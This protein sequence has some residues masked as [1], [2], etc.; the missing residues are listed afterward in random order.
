M[1]SKRSTLC[2]TVLLAASACSKSENMRSTKSVALTAHDVAEPSAASAAI[3]QGPQ[4]AYSYETSYALD[5][6]G[7]AAIQA[8]HIALCAKLGA[9]RCQVASSSV[10]DGSNDE[11]NASGEA[12]LV[13]AATLADSF[14]RQLDQAV[15]A[16]GGRVTN[17]GSTADDVTKQ[18]ID[19]NARLAAKQVLTDRL[20]VLI[21][22]ADGK[23]GDLVA[24]EKA[25]AEAQGE[26]EAARGEQTA[27]AQRVAMSDISLHYASRGSGSVF[28]PVGRALFGAGAALGWSLAGLVTFIVVSAPWIVMLSLLLWLLRRFGWRPRWPWRRR[29]PP[30]PQGE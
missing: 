1:L 23:V 8:R 20:L 27:L 11:G 3:Q 15:T 18:M 9:M 16:A 22:T 17:R 2:L 6:G 24:A 29:A 7:I 26:L 4:I 28:A 25:Y 30:M 10:S 19:V 12:K 14:G 5:G 21:R 13:V